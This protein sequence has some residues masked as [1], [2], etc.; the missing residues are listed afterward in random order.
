M[1]IV[2]NNDYIIYVMDKMILNQ[3]YCFFIKFKLDCLF[4]KIDYYTN[5]LDYPKVLLIW[6]V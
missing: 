2:L 3:E 4:S 1:P 6:L 5:L